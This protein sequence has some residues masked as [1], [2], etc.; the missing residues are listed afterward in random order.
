MDLIHLS[1][2]IAG[3]WIVFRNG[4]FLKLVV[5]YIPCG[6]GKCF[7]SRKGHEKVKSFAVCKAGNRIGD[8]QK[9]FHCLSSF[10][11][12]TSE[13]RVFAHSSINIADDL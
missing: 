13:T 10:T 11:K 4:M 1:K 8:D 6:D 3:F 2:A 5:S 12:A 7:T 9:I